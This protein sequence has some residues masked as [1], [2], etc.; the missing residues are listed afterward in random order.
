MIK[1]LSNGANQLLE[2]Y[3]LT[4]M[5][6]ALAA[7]T[8]GGVGN[9]TNVALIGLVLCAAGLTQREAQADLWV[10]GALAAYTALGALASWRVQGHFAWGYA[11]P[12]SIFLT[13]YLLMACLSGDELRLFRRLSVLWA[14][15]VAAH[16][17]F[18]FLSKALAGH[19]G[20]LGGLLGNPNAL[21][22]FLAVAWFGLNA[23]APGEEESGLL[24]AALRRM[25]PLLL[26]VLALTLSMGSFVSLAAGMLFLAAGWLRRDGWREASRQ[27]CRMVAKAGL[28]V[29]LGV[30][31][32]FTARMTDIP[33]FVLALAGYLAALTALWP[34]LDRF[35]RDLPWVSCAMTAAGALVAVGTVLIR[36]SSIATFAER[37]DMMR[38]GLGYIAQ[39][40]I[41]GVGAY[42]WRLLNL[43]DADPYFNTWHIHNVL[44]HVAVE[45]GLPAAAALVAV[46]VR[47]YWKKAP[48]RAGFTAFLVHNLMDTSFFYL[49]I[50]G[51]MEATAAEPRLGGRAL[52]SGAVR[53][54]FA[55]LA[56]QFAYT[57]Y[58][59]ISGGYVF[60]TMEHIAQLA[61]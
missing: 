32:Y 27:A 37:L 31:M 30:L 19:A 17:L 47:H 8:L 38:N 4:L 9:A 1:R 3:L 13:L 26:T 2:H 59:Y 60:T 36:P 40:P 42:Q 16:G 55:A 35:L 45:L 57:I 51:L 33:W 52:G 5:L 21:G 50:T 14:G 15:C 41:A 11:S 29:A 44:I 61:L 6:L 23:Q 24:P 49:G 34:R 46:I 48:N 28:A 25:E 53:L 18:L 7:L 10:V 12:Q 22:I 39:H 43:Q 54:L 20:R 56:A 58:V